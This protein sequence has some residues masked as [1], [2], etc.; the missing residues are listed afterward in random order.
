MD[1]NGGNREVLAIVQVR[2][3]RAMAV[4]ME[5]EKTSWR[6]SKATDEVKLHVW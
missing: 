1:S 5:V 3:V 4:G 2:D 6:G